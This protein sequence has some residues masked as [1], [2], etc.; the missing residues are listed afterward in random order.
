MA[1]EPASARAAA[2]SRANARAE[3]DAHAGMN[4][5]AGDARTGPNPDGSVVQPARPSRLAGRNAPP[6][7]DPARP[8]DPT[9]VELRRARNPFKRALL[10]LGPGLVT[11]ASD[12]DPSGVGTYAQ[13]GAQFGYATLWTTILMLPMMIAVQYMSAKVGLVSGRGLAGALRQHYPRWMLYGSLAA[14]VVANTL[15]AGADIGA[16]AASFNLLLP[17]VPGVAFVIPV[18]LGIA[19]IQLFGSY[20]LVVRVFKW[21]A[22]ALVAYVGA[23][24]FTRPDL[25]RVL[26]GSLVP[27]I[28]LDSKYLGIMVALLGTTISP[29]LFF[30]Q[31]SQEVD[32]QIAIGRKRLWQRRG[33]SLA[34]LRYTLAD[35]IAGMAFSEIVAYFIVLTAAATL[36]TS[37]KH[38]VSSA[39]DAAVALRPLAGD[40]SS[41]LLALG[42]IGSGV[43]AVPVLTGSAAY[44]TAEAFGWSAGLDRAPRKAPQF[45]AVIL[46]A[47]GVGMAINF[48]GINPIAA[49]VASAV[50]NGL[51]A[52]PVLLLLLLASNSKR[53]M[54]RRTNGRLLNLIGGLTAA[55][56]ALSAVSLLATTIL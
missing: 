7:I 27:T 52:A 19:A 35:T 37:G 12:D 21:L 29:Y 34:E 48:L 39:T 53:V 3:P 50:I 25:V 28:H 10:V 43:L 16:I 56:M 40:L 26:E 9:V 54:G 32:Q 6:R 18:G 38:D 1:S 5:H 11:G 33:A 44:A 42:L 30:W 14:L 24:L 13:A 49:L 2:N 47:T 31:S 41:A 45:Y 46:I 55:A 17:P 4:T 23:A 22:M 20:H 15:N 51:L 8:P 36:F